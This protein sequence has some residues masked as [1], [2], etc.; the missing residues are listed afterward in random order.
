MITFGSNMIIQHM[1]RIM[2]GTQNLSLSVLVLTSCHLG[3][4]IDRDTEEETTIQILTG[5]QWAY[6]QTAKEA[7]KPRERKV[8]GW[9]LTE[10]IAWKTLRL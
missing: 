7:R 2:P 6:P 10:A 5:L 8:G 9:S 3:V 4:I 1:Y